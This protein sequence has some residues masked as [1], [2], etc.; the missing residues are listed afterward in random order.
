MLPKWIRTQ[1]YTG[2]SEKPDS[3]MCRPDDLLA[4]G[5]RSA[6]YVMFET[7]PTCKHVVDPPALRMWEKKRMTDRHINIHPRRKRRK[8]I[9]S[10]RFVES[11]FEKKINTATSRKS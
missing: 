10:W 5:C 4:T 11:T 3:P 6:L 2:S 9:M 7:I 1:C 8:S